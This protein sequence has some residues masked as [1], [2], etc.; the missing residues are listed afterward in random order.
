MQEVATTVGAGHP[1][2]ARDVIHRR[3]RFGRCDAKH[4][5]FSVQA[6]RR[7]VGGCLGHLLQPAC[8]VCQYSMLRQVNCSIFGI[9][10]YDNIFDH[11]VDR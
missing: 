9:L 3:K 6:R 1:V 7:K 2:R 5:G 8:F 11:H 10:L 4:V